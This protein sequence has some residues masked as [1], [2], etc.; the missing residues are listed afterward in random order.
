MRVCLLKVIEHYHRRHDSLRSCVQF[1]SLAILIRVPIGNQYFFFRLKFHQIFITVNFT[2]RDLV[3]WF[4]KTLF[5]MPINLLIISSMSLFP[6]GVNQVEFPAS[7]KVLI[8]I[9]RVK[10]EQCKTA[11]R[12]WIQL[13]GW[14]EVCG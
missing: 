7:Q 12:I 13:D 5:L 8:T 4:Q 10:A 1:S 6:L 11:F 2:L 3:V 9:I 14:L